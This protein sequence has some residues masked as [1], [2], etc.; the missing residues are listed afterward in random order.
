MTSKKLVLL[1]T[2]LCLT[3]LL[4]AS[5]ITRE[6]L[7]G[8]I[9]HD[10]GSD[11]I[12][13][14]VPSQSGMQNGGTSCAYQATFNG[15]AL[16]DL[17]MSSAEK[18]QTLL[19]ALKDTQARH[20]KFCAEDSPWR[21]EV[22]LM[23]AQGVNAKKEIEEQ[24]GRSY[25]GASFP[26]SAECKEDS[27]YK[28]LPNNSPVEFAGTP[29]AEAILLDKLWS[30]NGTIA[31][32]ISEAHREIVN[33]SLTYTVSA[34]EIK[35]A[36]LVGIQKRIDDKATEDKTPYESLNNEA[37]LSG[38]I[39]FKD[40]TVNIPLASVNSNWLESHEILR[41]LTTEIKPHMAPTFISSD[42]TGDMPLAGDPSWKTSEALKTFIS[43]FQ[44]D[45]GNQTGIFLV[46]VSGLTSEPIT[47]SSEKEFYSQATNCSTNGHW[48]TIVAHKVGNQRQFIAAD[49]LGNPSR[50]NHYR[51]KEIKS[52][53]E[54]KDYVKDGS[55]AKWLEEA[56]PASAGKYLKTM[57]TN[58]SE[59][60]HKNP[61]TAGLI[62][63]F[64]LSVLIYIYTDRQQ[65]AIYRS[66]ENLIQH[67]HPFAQIH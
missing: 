12:Q 42:L 65:K 24:I 41:L 33:G 47:W 27:L 43:E 15:Q 11:I 28:R 56:R 30:E 4:H 21:Q 23:R 57:R 22:L 40:V 16:H 17:L 63:G 19:A 29:A 20:H 46:Y 10:N 54:G 44:K 31:R 58:A 26:T 49:S 7:Q 35:Q 34:Q 62:G 1:T 14:T 38:F 2:T 5:L 37:R 61:F 45:D 66:P 25:K 53:L 60:I 6:Q 50:I 8:F 55:F 3:G 48:Y 52:I 32:N 9:A 36:F 39:D 51:L 59:F 64:A 67:D 13:I 18:R